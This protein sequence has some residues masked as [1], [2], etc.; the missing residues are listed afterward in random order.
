MTSFRLGAETLLASPQWLKKLKGRRTAYLGHAASVQ[1]AAAPHHQGPGGFHALSHLLNQKEIRLTA[2]FS[3]QH[4][5][6]AARQANM[7]PSPDSAL[8]GLPLFSL[9]SEKTRRLTPEMKSLFDVL[10]VDL[11]DAGCRIY[12]YLTALFYLIEDCGAAGKSL[13]ILDRPNPLGRNIEG[14]LLKMDFQSYVGAAPMPM[15]HGLTLGEA[16]LWLKSRKKLKTDVQVIPMEG[17]Q[18]GRDGGWPP[19]RPWIFPSPNMTGA[20]CAKCY[21]GTVLLE[22]AAVSEGRG[23]CL[24]FQVF[25]FPGMRAREIKRLMLSRGKSFLR[26]C[27]LREHEFEPAFDKFKGRA[28]SGFQIHTEKLWAEKGAF[29]P[30]R[31]ISLF[32]KALREV[33]PDRPWQLPPP[34]EYEEKLL[35]IDIISGSSALREWVEDPKA[36]AGE[37]D[38]FL[39]GEEGLWRREIQDFYIYKQPAAEKRFL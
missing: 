8:A 12:T 18:P 10:L 5:F 11:Q 37:W 9:Y 7:I 15:S 31:L 23:T 6:H 17:Y 19:G 38:D 20:A 39:T 29:R 24:P 25:G 2:L 4:G 13:W 22:G 21:P 3:P 33:H 26:G 30:Y 14:N 16:A 34:Y 28:C 36:S 32:L 35:P 1:A 27:Y